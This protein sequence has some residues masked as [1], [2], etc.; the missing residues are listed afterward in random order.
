MLEEA[1]RLLRRMAERTDVRALRQGFATA[2][3]ECGEVDTQVARLLGHADTMVPRRPYTH[4]YEK[5]D[6]AGIG[7]SSMR[8]SVGPFR[9]DVVGKW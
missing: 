3:L 5:R 9:S 2:L 4:A 7:R 6:V 8:S 1:R